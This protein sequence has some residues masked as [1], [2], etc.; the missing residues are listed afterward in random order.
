[1]TDPSKMCSRLEKLIYMIFRHVVPP[2]F[3]IVRWV[4]DAIFLVNLRNKDLRPNLSAYPIWFFAS[5]ARVVSNAW[6]K[7]YNDYALLCY[8]G[9]IKFHYGPEGRGY[10]NYDS[11]ADN[12]KLDL[13]GEPR[14]RLEHFL[15]CNS[16]VLTYVDGDSFLDV[17]CGRGQNVKILLEYFPT[18]AI[19]A[20][21]INEGAVAVARLGVKDEKR[22]RVKVGSLT[23]SD[24]L[25]NYSSNEFDHVLV[26]HVFS[27]LMGEGE[28]ATRQL[29]QRIIDDLV[30]IARKTLFIV[31][32]PNSLNLFEPSFQIEQKHRAFFSESII[33]YFDDHAKEGELCVLF[34]PESVG[35]LFTKRSH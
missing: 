16:G 4:Q 24:Y 3:W 27:F 25:T 30:R 20:C 26:S 22:I 31:D 8:S 23:D 12:E 11:L 19:G 21:D 2:W 1:M 9:L 15:G 10:F 5:I 29:R 13:Y 33:P 14:G 17:G 7:A 6:R 32:G 34:S 18:S 28:L 35:I